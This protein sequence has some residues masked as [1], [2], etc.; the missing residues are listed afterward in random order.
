MKIPFSKMHGAG[1][2]LVVID[3]LA[4]DPLNIREDAF[5]LN[6]VGG[7][8]SDDVA[9]LLASMVNSFTPLTDEGVDAFVYLETQ[10]EPTQLNIGRVQEQDRSIQQQGQG[11]GQQG[12]IIPETPWSP[13]DEIPTVSEWG[14]IVM[15]V[16]G[17]SAGTIMYGRRRRPAAA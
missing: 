8:T 9:N 3:C 16:L 1:N 5:T 14:L 12:G 15:T 7:E 11:Q 17:L 2:D 13:G 10:D 4:G 6:L